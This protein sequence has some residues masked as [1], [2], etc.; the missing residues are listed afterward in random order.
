MKRRIVQMQPQSASGGVRS[1][2]RATFWL[3]VA[4]RAGTDRGFVD[5]GRTGRPLDRSALAPRF[6]LRPRPPPP[7]PALWAAGDATRCDAARWRGPTLT[8]ATRVLARQAAPGP[9]EQLLR[10]VVVTT[11]R[12]ICTLLYLSRRS[13]PRPRAR[14]ATRAAPHQPAA[15]SSAMAT[16]PMA[17]RAMR[18]ARAGPRNQGGCRCVRG[19]R[20]PVEQN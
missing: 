11:R 6:G 14:G 8:R 2:R 4:P 13:E 3:S 9:H 18:S 1:A 7:S 20:R 16:A 19:D 5:R 12:R 15:R 17:A 10:R